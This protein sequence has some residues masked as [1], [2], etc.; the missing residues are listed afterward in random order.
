MEGGFIK[1]SR[2]T[3]DSWIMANLHFRFS[4]YRATPGIH[5]R[6]YNATSSVAAI[7]FLGG[8]NVSQPTLTGETTSTGSSLD[9]TS[10]CYTLLAMT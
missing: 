4:L 1:R 9:N 5:M 8:R 7:P 10:D 6:V 2:K 3:R